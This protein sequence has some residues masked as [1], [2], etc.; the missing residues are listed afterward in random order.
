MTWRDRDV[1]RMS[2]ASR[3][4]E[5][6]SQKICE[7]KGKSVDS[8]QLSGVEGGRKRKSLSQLVRASDSGITVP[9]AGLRR[10]CHRP[11]HE[12]NHSPHSVTHVCPLR[13]LQTF[14]QQVMEGRAAV[15]QAVSVITFALCLASAVLLLVSLGI[16]TFFK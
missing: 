11:K 8:R 13:I 7:G 16:F 3:E 9:E 1:F 14:V 6:L 2:V 5:L 12:L 4:R 10:H 15:R